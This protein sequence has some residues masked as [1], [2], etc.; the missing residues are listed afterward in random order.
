MARISTK[1]ELAK[2]SSKQPNA[3][4]AIRQQDAVSANGDWDA[5][6]KAIIRDL[7]SDKIS[8]TQFEVFLKAARYLRLNPFSK[9]IY[10]VPYQGRMVIQVGIDGF[11]AWADRTGK[12]RGFTEAE[13]L[14]KD[15]SGARS[16]ISYR[17]YDPD[18]HQIVNATIGIYHADDADPTYVTCTFKGYA[19]VFNGK[20]SDTWEKNGANQ[21]VK[22]CKAL[23]VRTRFP[24][25]GSVYAPEEMG[26]IERQAVIDAE[27]SIPQANAPQI[28]QG[29]ENEPEHP[30]PTDRAA[31]AKDITANIVPALQ[32][33]HPALQDEN[34]MKGAYVLLRKRYGVKSLADITAKQYSDLENWIETEEF[35][36]ELRSNFVLPKEVERE[37]GEDG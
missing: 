29:S 37:P 14:V 10:A 16:H 33:R 8:N 30:E 35:Q 7:V 34:R 24:G 25:M 11:L 19:S 17:D 13:F 26:F 27:Y 18:E 4:V 6:E 23:A 15:T 36:G 12:F 20:L 31:R 9:E 5:K 22:C 1:T 32:K 21:L 3:N 28:P 2:A